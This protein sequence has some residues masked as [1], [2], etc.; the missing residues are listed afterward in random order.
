[1]AVDP[2]TGNGSLLITDRD[3]RSSTT[4]HLEFEGHHLVKVSGMRPEHMNGH[5][6]LRVMRLLG[7]ALARDSNPGYAWRPAPGLMDELRTLATRE[8]TSV[9]QL[10]RSAVENFVQKENKHD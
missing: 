2:V 6:M 5:D 9:S 10:I 4:I 8:G 7:G 3:G 1:M